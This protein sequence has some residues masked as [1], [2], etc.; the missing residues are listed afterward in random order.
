MRKR[1]VGDGWNLMEEMNKEKQQQQSKRKHS[2]WTLSLLT[3]L[4]TW[5]MFCSSV[6]MMANLIMVLELR[7]S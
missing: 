6:P 4:D 3:R 1:W 7:P 2:S 5:K